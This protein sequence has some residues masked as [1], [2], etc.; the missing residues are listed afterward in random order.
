L[1]NGGHAQTACG[2][3]EVRHET[4]AVHGAVNAQGGVRRDDGH[5]GRA[6]ETEVLLRLLCRGLSIATRNAHAF[7]QLQCAVQPALA[8]DA[9]VFGRPGEIRPRFVG[10][11]S[12][13]QGRAEAL[14][15]SAF[16]DV[17]LPWLRVAPGSGALRHGED[18]SLERS[19]HGCWQKPPTAVARLQQAIQCRTVDSGYGFKSCIHV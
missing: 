18:L 6:K 4:A 11:P 13:Q 19:R 8:V 5:M 3:K 10:R 16:G 9:P 17:N 7:I 1:R 14:G 2:Q 15:G 12:R